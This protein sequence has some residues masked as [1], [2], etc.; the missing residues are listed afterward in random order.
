MNNKRK[1]N[2]IKVALAVWN[3]LVFAEVCTDAVISIVN[4]KETEAE[5]RL[6]Y[7]ISCHIIKLVLNLVLHFLV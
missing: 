1:K 6:R 2:F 4:R 5:Y 7:N 3:S